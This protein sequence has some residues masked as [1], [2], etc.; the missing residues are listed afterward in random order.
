ML[1]RPQNRPTI[2]GLDK[3]G[4]KFMKLTLS[5]I[6]MDPNCTGWT[7]ATLNTI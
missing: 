2:A 4:S 1:D 7:V 3:P 5:T 6:P